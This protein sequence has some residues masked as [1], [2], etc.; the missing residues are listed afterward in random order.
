M[1]CKCGNDI[2]DE[3]VAVLKKYDLPLVCVECAE[4]KTFKYTAHCVTEGKSG[5]SIQVIKDAKTGK[6]LAKASKRSASG[7]S[8]RLNSPVTQSVI[9]DPKVDANEYFEQKAE[10]EL[11]RKKRKRKK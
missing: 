6:Y 3:R 7:I 5:D 2:P 8:I 11:A 9:S 4:K 10:E 1:K